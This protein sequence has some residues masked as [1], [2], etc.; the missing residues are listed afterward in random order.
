M[1]NLTVN[2]MAGL[3]LFIA[4]SDIILIKVYGKPASYSANII[5]WTYKHR[6]PFFVGFFVGVVFGH[7]FWSMPTDTVYENIE[8]K[9]KSE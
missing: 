4:I 8:C 5:R 7:L 6:K 9:E 2:I 3:V 1:E